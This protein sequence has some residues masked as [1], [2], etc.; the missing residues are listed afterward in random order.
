M[1]EIISSRDDRNAL[2]TIR[3]LLPGIYRG[4]RLPG[5]GSPLPTALS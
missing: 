1:T 4:R 2:L 3:I 5:I